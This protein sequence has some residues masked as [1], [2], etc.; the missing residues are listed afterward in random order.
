MVAMMDYAILAPLISGIF[1]EEV[2]FALTDT[3]QYLLYQPTV[4][5]N[6]GI[7]PGDLVKPESASGVCMVSGKTEKRILPKEVLGIP[8]YVIAIPIRDEAGKVMGCVS[9][10]RSLERFERINSVAQVLAGAIS[11][12]SQQI[13]GMKEKL[14]ELSHVNQQ[15][16]EGARHSIDE[17]K[18]SD[19]I[20][21]FIRNVAGQT[22]LLGL[23]AAIEAARS[24]EAGR[25]FTVVAE[26]IR[27]LSASTGASVGKIGAIIEAMRASTD[28][29][30]HSVAANS[31]AF[32]AQAKALEEIA[33]DVAQIAQTA[34]ELAEIS[35]KM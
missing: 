26:E 17:M 33:G 10:G 1:D 16:E 21:Q 25:G 27:K 9:L 23:N 30:S 29:I 20:L 24:G 14:G 32:A 28:E 4:H 5:I 15:L 19:S 22:N 35:K 34:G 11:D 2:S 8:L 7:K 6:P 3:K 12:L 13:N 31:Q 18:E